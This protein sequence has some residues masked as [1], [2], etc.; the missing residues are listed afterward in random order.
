MPFKKGQ[1]GN[2]KGRPPSKV[3]EPL[4]DDFKALGPTAI[5]VLR[6]ELNKGNLRAA[7]YVID[8]IHGKS[9]QRLETTGADGGPIKRQ[10]VNED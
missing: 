5:N 9:T 6:S 2:P 7:M 10:T 1:S 3:N 8:H 4:T